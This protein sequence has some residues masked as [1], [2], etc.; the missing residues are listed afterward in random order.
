MQ[1]VGDSLLKLYLPL[2]TLQVAQDLTNTMLEFMS[3]KSL[4]RGSV[5]SHDDDD[6]KSIKFLMKLFLLHRTMQWNGEK[7]EP[8]K[9]GSRNANSFLMVMISQRKLRQRKTAQIEYFG[10]CTSEFNFEADSILKESET[11]ITGN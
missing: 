4:V 9:T 5:L 7:Y 2:F 10:V 1:K 3:I 8:N 11:N 6:E